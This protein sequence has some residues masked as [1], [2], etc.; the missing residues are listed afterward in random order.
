MMKKILLSSI[1]LFCT[2]CFATGCTDEKLDE[3]PKDEVKGNCSIVECMKKIEATNTIEEISNIIGFDST[4]DAMIG[5]D[6]IWKFDSKNWISYNNYNDDITI[7]ATINKESIK[8]DQIELPSSSDLQK[9]LNN[10]S[11]TYEEFVKKVGGEG[12]L[13]TISKGSLS[14]TWVDKAGIR[15]GATFNNKSGKCTVA[16]YR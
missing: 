9:D 6:P 4:T 3:K 2:L 5:S 15:L 1:M 14:Y 10:G 11:F 16:S 8:N 7:Q 12:T 13:T